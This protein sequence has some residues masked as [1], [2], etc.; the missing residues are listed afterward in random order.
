MRVSREERIKKCL[1][2]KTNRN[3]LYF[4]FWRDNMPKE[5]LEECLFDF[6]INDKNEKELFHTKFEMACSGDGQEYRKMGNIR[7]SSLCSLLFFYNVSEKNPIIINDIK[8]TKSYFE[9]KNRVFNNPSNMDVVLLGNSKDG[10]KYILFIECKFSEY[11]YPSI[12]KISNAYRENAIS[13]SIYEK[14]I[15]NE[16]FNE[17]KDKVDIGYGY[18]KS[19]QYMEGLKQIISHYVGLHNYANRNKDSYMASEKQKEIYKEDYDHICFLEV[20]FKFKGEFNHEYNEYKTESRKLT[21]I[22]K[23]EVKKNKDKIEYLDMKT[24]QDILKVKENDNY[25][26]NMKETIKEYYNYN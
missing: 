26:N 5:K 7:S 23:E 1:N 24:Y 25:K 4:D 20:V 14:A 22:I 10:E 18:Y 12:L 9:I 19:N 21:K 11:L 6:F 15:E 8:Y 17:V 3:P 13:N 2:I 16:V